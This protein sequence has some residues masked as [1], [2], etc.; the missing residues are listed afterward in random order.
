MGMNEATWIR[1]ASAWSVWTRFVILPLLVFSIWARVWLGWWCLVPFAILIVWTRVNPRA[2]PPPKTTK[3]WEARA[4]MG[5]RVWLARKET[6]IPKHHARMAM[7][8]SS[9][10]GTG[11]PFLV[12][13]LWAYEIWATGLGVVLTIVFKMWFLDRMVWLFDDMARENETYASWLH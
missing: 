12:Y 7:L 3:R 5:E 1:H 4:V 6:P 10:A 11:L 13:G 2:F 8:L 9:M